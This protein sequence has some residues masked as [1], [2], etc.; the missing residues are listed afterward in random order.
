MLPCILGTILGLLA[1]YYGGWL[2]TLLFRLGD[3][4]QA[5]PQ[6]VLMIVLV[7]ILGSGVPSIVVSFTIVGWVVYARLTRTE[8]LRIKETQFVMAA[9]TSGFSSLRVMGR[10]ILPNVIRQV[11]IYLTSDLVFSVVALAAFSFLGFGVQQPTPEW[12]VMIS[13]GQRYLNL[14]PWLVMVPGICLSVFAVGLAL[15]GDAFQDKG[16]H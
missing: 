7:F 13:S 8:V 2:D 15:L 16:E 9:E 10:H 6:Y 4:L 5:F 14:A 1:G 12:G 3:L 11:A